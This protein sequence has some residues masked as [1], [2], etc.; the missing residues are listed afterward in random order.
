[1]QFRGGPAAV[2]GDAGRPRGFCPVTSGISRG[3]AADSQLIR[4]PEDLL[5]NVKLSCTDGKGA[6]TI[7]RGLSGLFC[8][9]GAV[10]GKPFIA[11]MED[12]MKKSAKKVI[13]Y[14][15]RCLQ[16]GQ[17]TGLSHYIL[18]APKAERSN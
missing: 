2:I 16:L 12:T 9:P 14:R 10:P 8:C 1:V 7:L 11:F 13:S 4:E 17:N 15:R 3:K 6:R 18:L 5:S